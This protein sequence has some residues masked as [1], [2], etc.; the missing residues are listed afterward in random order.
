MSTSSPSKKEG[1]GNA[2]DQKELGEDVMKA[3]DKIEK[4]LDPKDVRNVMKAY[5]K[6]FSGDRISLLEKSVSTLRAKTLKLQDK[7]DDNKRSS[8]MVITELKRQVAECLDTIETLKTEN[9]G[10]LQSAENT[11]KMT[12]EKEVKML[13]RHEDDIDN[14]KSELHIVKLK[15]REA[16]GFLANKATMTSQLERQGK[17]LKNF[18]DRLQSEKKQLQE[19]LKDL[20]ER[21]TSERDKTHADYVKLKEKYDVLREK[22]N[23]SKKS[24]RFA[25]ISK[26]KRSP[27]ASYGYMSKMRLDNC[28]SNVITKPMI[29]RLDSRERKLKSSSSL[30]AIPVVRNQASGNK[31]GVAAAGGSPKHQG[32]IDNSFSL[33]NFIILPKYNIQRDI[34]SLFAGGTR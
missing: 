11:A 24:K 1:E 29:S 30:P 17:M 21:S 9:K 7:M 4:D 16:E 19:Q 14:M 26:K 2:P 3:L 18:D 32:R 20:I 8:D 31:S 10:L 25:H 12:A 34:K 13:A 6:R 33:K 27:K 15:C 28:E 23:L 22:F 5:A